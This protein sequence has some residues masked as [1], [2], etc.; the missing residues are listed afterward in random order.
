MKIGARREYL[1]AVKERYN[2]SSKKE[3]GQI[4]NEFCRNCDYCR[5][6]AIKLISGKIEHREYPKRK[7]APRRYSSEVSD[8]LAYLWKVMGNPH[9]LALKASLYHWLPYDLDCNEDLAKKLLAMSSS[10]IERHLKPWKKKLSKGKSATTPPKIKLQI[11][12]ELLHD[13]H[14]EQIGYFEADTVAHCGDSLSGKFAWSLTVTDI[15]SGW[16]ENRALYSKLAEG[17]VRC[18][19]PHNLTDFE[20]PNP[21][22]FDRFSGIKSHIV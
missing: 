1:E 20:G 17:V 11:P 5:K 16:T 3:K 6:H 7:G 8:K 9:S 12:L 15:C 18:P 2:K 14:R 19:V 4:L 21:T 22:H 10:T 13:D